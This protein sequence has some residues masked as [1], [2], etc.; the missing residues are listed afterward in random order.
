MDLPDGGPPTDPPQQAAPFFTSRLTMRGEDGALHTIRTTF[1]PRYGLMRGDDGTWMEAPIQA[2]VA[3]KRGARDVGAAFPAEQLDLSGPSQPQ[4]QVVEVVRA[5]AD[6][7]PVD[8]GTS[9]WLIGGLV[10]AAGL[11]MT[12]LV[13]LVLRRRGS[14]GTSPAAPTPP[15]G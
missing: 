1:V 5:P 12:A 2:E 14:A 6:P 15:G 10:L 7:A 9:P 13:A 3:F 11:A 4:A 8:E